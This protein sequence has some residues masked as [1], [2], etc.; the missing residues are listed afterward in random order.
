[1]TEQQTGLD[2]GGRRFLHPGP[3][4]WLRAT[5]WM[6]LLTLVFGFAYA[7]IQGLPTSAPL[8]ALEVLAACVVAFGAYA[9]VVWLCEG[10]WPEELKLS[11]APL[12]LLA[13]CAV[14]AVI[15]AAVVGLLCLLGVYEVSGPHAGS[16]WRMLTIAIESGFMEELIVRAIIA[17]LLMRAFGAWPSLVLQAALFGAAHLGN[18]NATPVA[19]IAI[20]VEAGFLLAA[21]YMLTGRLWVSIGVH[22]AWNFTQGWLWGAPVSGTP[23][24]PSLL[25]SGPKPGAP[26]FLSGGAFGPE[27]SLPCIV[28]G[29]GVAIVVLRW[30]WKKGNFKT[31]PDAVV[32]G[33]A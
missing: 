14:G 19:A 2:V 11:A 16:P 23:R 25:T 21:F 30:A 13:G 3:L 33:A 27:A 15:M 4:R 6:V 7:F 29:T 28:V 5:A 12:E 18:P 1:M 17:R 26:E 24:T 31:R 32:P 9:G 10:R 8:D 20:A 22:A